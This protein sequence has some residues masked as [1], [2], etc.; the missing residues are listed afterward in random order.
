MLNTFLTEAWGLKVPIIGA[1]MS[2]QAGG[3]LV[4]ALTNAGALG[5]IGVAA[6]QPTD[7]LAADVA[8]VR[9]R[10]GDR[11]FGIG[12]MAWALAARSEL[13]DAALAAKPFAISV[14][15]GDPAPCAARVLDAGVRLI[16]QVQD[17][18]SALAAVAAGASLIVAQ[19][20][21]AGGHTGDVG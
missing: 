20:T 16:C 18:R 14:S 19:G 7:Q 12:L 6:G 1:P 3:H 13:L 21:E 2:P 4:A 17:R 8:E 10:A 11:P 9:E 5:M 15:F